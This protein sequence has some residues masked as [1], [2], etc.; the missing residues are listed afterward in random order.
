M[1]IRLFINQD[2]DNKFTEFISL[3]RAT[4]SFYNKKNV[5]I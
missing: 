2:C 1:I 4:K 3:Y 5:R